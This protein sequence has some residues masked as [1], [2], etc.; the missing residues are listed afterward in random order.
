MC[1]M[2]KIFTYM[3]LCNI[4]KNFEKNQQEIVD[5]K[6]IVRILNPKKKKRIALFKVFIEIFYI[7]YTHDLPRKIKYTT[8]LH[9]RQR[10]NILQRKYYFF[11]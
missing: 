6:K 7:F 5:S 11:L 4:I 1:K 9:Y 10:T 8:A 2:Y 3:I